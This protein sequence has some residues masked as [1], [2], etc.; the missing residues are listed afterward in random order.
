ML[1]SA[2]A[3]DVHGWP[4]ETL[5]GAVA[6]ASL[7]FFGTLFENKIFGQVVSVPR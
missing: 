3:A 7:G 6:V 2:I 4:I 1:L 5:C